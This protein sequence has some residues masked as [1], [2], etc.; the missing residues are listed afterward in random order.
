MKKI[1]FVITFL[2]AFMGL[3]A[4][5]MQC[6]SV[7]LVGA[8][9]EVSIKET[10]GTSFLLGTSD[11]ILNL[12]GLAYT[13]AV[14]GIVKTTPLPSPYVVDL[15]DIGS[16]QLAISVLHNNGSKLIG[17]TKEVLVNI[18][19]TGSGTPTLTSSIIYNTSAAQIGQLC[20]I[21]LP[22]ELLS[23]SAEK[24]GEKSAVQ[25]EIVNEK[26][27]SYYGV[28]RSS[29]GVNF[30][31]IDFEKPVAKDENQRV[32]YSFLDEKPELGINYY[33]IQIKD[34]DGNIKYSKV[35]SVDFGSKIKAKTYP[36][37]FSTDLSVEIDIEKNIKGDVTIDVVD[38]TGKIVQTKKLVAE[39]RRVS[40]NLPMDGLTSGT[41]LIR[42]KNGNDTWQ[43]KITK[44]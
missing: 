18:P 7:A 9:I 40:F 36:N 30:K 22:I 8:N 35:V 11:V 26:S 38:M 39:G 44:Q 34:L 43:Q 32:N 15:F 23:F 19:T 37:P 2:Y 33:R 5:S 27:L 25:W 41:Y 6:V 17:S 4:Q 20:P 24:S 42:M 12:G 21:A 3:Q 14:E 16:G 28:E 13:T 1:Y 31:V 10:N 29:D